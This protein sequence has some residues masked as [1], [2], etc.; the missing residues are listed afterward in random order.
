MPL[1]GK[2]KLRSKKEQELF[3]SEYMRK[4]VQAPAANA[5]THSF[6]SKSHFSKK[7]KLFFKTEN[8]PRGA[9]RYQ[10]TANKIRVRKVYKIILVHLDE[11]E[12]TVFHVHSLLC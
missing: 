4:T 12:E 10:S 3:S 5:S 1:R 11:P 8:S 6:I 2:Q 9:L 7:F